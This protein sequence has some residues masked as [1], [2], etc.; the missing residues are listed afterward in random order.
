MT[1]ESVSPV[2]RILQPLHGFRMTHTAFGR[3]AFSM[4]PPSPEPPDTA[5]LRMRPYRTAFIVGAIID[6]PLIRCH[7]SGGRP[8]AVP[9][10]R[11]HPE[12]SRGIYSPI[13]Q[14]RSLHSLR[15][16]EMTVGNGLDRSAYTVLRID[17]MAKAIPYNTPCLSLRTSAH[18]GVAI[19]PHGYC[20]FFGPPVA[21]L[22]MTP[23][24]FLLFDSIVYFFF[25]SCQ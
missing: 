3:A 17:G 24:P 16:V 8:M 21:A 15:S 2:L 1:E 11:C 23:C 19:R 6:R 25:K 12:R 22:R 9:T 18:T 10:M 7:P 5:A 20:G 4:R 13:V 14:N